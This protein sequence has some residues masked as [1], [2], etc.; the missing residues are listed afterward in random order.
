LLQATVFLLSALLLPGAFGRKEPEDG[1]AN[2]VKQ[3]QN[4]PMPQRVRSSDTK[5]DDCSYCVFPFIYNVRNW[6]YC[7]DEISEANYSLACATQVDSDG[8]LIEWDFCAPD[9][10]GASKDSTPQVDANPLNNPGQCYCGMMNSNDAYAD[11]KIVGGDYASMG[12]LP[13]QVGILQYSYYDSKY[14]E[15]CGG[16]LVG[17]QYVITAAH[18]VE[19]YTSDDT[20]VSVGNTIIG[21]PYESKSFLIGVEQI[22]T[23]PKYDYSGM[24][25]K[26]DI[27]ILRLSEKVDLYKFPHIKPACLPTKGQEWGYGVVSGWGMHESGMDGWY[28]SVLKYVDVELYW[29]GYCGDIESS[30]ISQDMLCAG[31]WEGGK[32][33][34]WGDDGGPLV[35]KSLANSDSYFLTGVTSWGDGCGVEGKPWV[36]ANVSY[37]HDFLSSNMPD[38]FT[39]P[40]HGYV[41]GQEECNPENTINSLAVTKKIKKIPTKEECRDICGG[42]KEI[43]DFWNFKNNKNKKKR[44]CYLLKT[45]SK[46]KK[47]FDSGAR[48]CTFF[49][50]WY[51]ST[52]APTTSD[53]MG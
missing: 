21:T 7:T 5:Q 47:G 18:C 14:Y 22:I 11:S 40:P 53:W 2:F 45:K 28:Q 8:R 27:S 9:C 30:K 39:C 36:Y 37:F 34:C 1:F 6:T 31:W 44:C 15:N 52:Y 32:D 41:P 29:P 48:G 42:E 26:N 50:P 25:P 51:T 3:E 13:W 19:W 10:K 49:E 12:Q 17:D 23:H 43:C 46:S 35:A 24:E 38:L 33:P 20:M 4:N 16:T